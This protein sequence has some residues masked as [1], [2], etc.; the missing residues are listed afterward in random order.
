MMKCRKTS[1]QRKD[2]AARVAKHLLKFYFAPSL[3]SHATVVPVIVAS[4][5]VNKKNSKSTYAYCPLINFCS[6]FVTNVRKI[7]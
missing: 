2:Y 7:F 3:G 5:N 4:P 6:A 1:N